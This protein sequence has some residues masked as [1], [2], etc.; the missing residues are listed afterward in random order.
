MHACQLN[1][2][3]QPNTKEHDHI[4]SS[5]PEKKNNLICQLN[6]RTLIA[7]T[8]TVQPNVKIA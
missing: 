1:H 8:M 5:T 2:S 4:R 6:Y 3:D 7:I